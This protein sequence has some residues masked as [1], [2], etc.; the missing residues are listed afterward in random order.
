[1]KNLLTQWELRTKTD[2]KLEPCWLSFPKVI[3]LGLTVF[4][5]S[6]HQVGT[7]AKPNDILNVTA[8]YLANTLTNTNGK[9]KNLTVHRQTYI[10]GSGGLLPIFYS[11]SQDCPIVLNKCQDSQILLTLYL[12][13][14]AI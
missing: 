5:W 3:P 10:Y 1:M 13:F 9:A 14:K 8:Y 6:Y 12:S 11:K 4:C 2:P 7:L